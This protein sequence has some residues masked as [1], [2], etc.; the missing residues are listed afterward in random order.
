MVPFGQETSAS[1]RCRMNPTASRS[2]ARVL[3]DALASIRLAVP[4]M[5]TLG[6]ACLTATIY[7]SKHGTAA[8]QRDFYR[9]LW[10]A[11]ILVLLGINIFCAMM[12]RYPWKKHH[13][14]FVMA[15]IGILTL[16]TGSLWSL[17]G[18]FDGNMALYEGETTDRVSLLDKVVDVDLPG[19]GRGRVA[20]DFEKNPPSPERPRRFALKG[21]DVTLVAEGFE[22]HVRTVDTFAA[23][24]DGPSA[25]RFMLEG[26][27]GKQDAWLVAGDPERHSLA[28][29]AATF[30]FFREGEPE[31]T[32]GSEGQ[33]RIAFVLQ[34]DGTLTYRLTAAKYPSQQGPVTVGTPVQT[35]WMGMKI[36]VAELLTHAE[37]DH[38][39]VPDTPPA[40]DER[41]L[42]AV[43]VHLE[44]RDARTPPAWVAWSS[45]VKLPYAG[46]TAAVAYHAPELETPFR[47]TLVDFNSDKYP[48]SNMAATY[49]SYVRVDD[50]ESGTSEHHISM[51]H[52]L[53]YRGY[54]F[55]QASF[56]EGQP[57]MSIFSVA[58][59]PGLP[60]VYLGSTLIALG[61]VWMFYVKPYLARRQAAV[62][63]KAH[64]EREARHAENAPTPDAPAAAAGPAAPASSGA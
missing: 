36:T 2:A 20:F 60:L 39:V 52:P 57:M 27:F 14:G 21:T 23:A 18:G 62:A 11:G 31:A 56:V 48:G 1:D 4:V 37:A 35:P 55:F 47:V 64:R 30:A 28:M 17:W 61:V 45:L 13:I 9:T 54:I 12:S 24:A 3:F 44:G 16:L 34:S 5:V 59:A 19:G 43:R 42:P 32:Q 51:N 25:I 15:H 6:L 10:F 58:R 53:H 26:P 22:P 38:D 33:N 7:E 46:R 8:A 49:E 63:L 50:P 29:G 41:R 40:D